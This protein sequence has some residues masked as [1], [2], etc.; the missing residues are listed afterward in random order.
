MKRRSFLKGLVGL[1]GV[2][3]CGGAR[4]ATTPLRDQRPTRTFG[5]L[6]EGGLE[7]KPGESFTVQGDPLGCGKTQPSKFGN[8]TFIGKSFVLEDQTMYI[9]REAYVMEF[10]A[11]ETRNVLPNSK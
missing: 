3:A 8:P 10:F 4:A 9:R 7:L 2:A 5:R 6:P 11:Y 1:L